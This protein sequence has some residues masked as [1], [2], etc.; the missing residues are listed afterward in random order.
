MTHEQYYLGC[1]TECSTFT[2]PWYGRKKGIICRI[3]AEKMLH[4]TE[5]QVE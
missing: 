2:F 1:I 4:Y 3:V 5:K